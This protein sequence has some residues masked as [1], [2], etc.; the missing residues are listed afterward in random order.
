MWQSEYLKHYARGY[1]FV[2][3][4]GVEQARVLALKK[5]ETHVREKRLF[6][7]EG[8]E[9]DE[10]DLDDIERHLNTLKDDLSKDPVIIKNDAVF[11]EGSD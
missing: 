7:Y 10:D 8:W 3:A 2:E 6:I 1:I 9:P 4:P 5:F 11:I